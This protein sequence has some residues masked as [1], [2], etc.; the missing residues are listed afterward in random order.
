MHNC[1][2]LVTHLHLDGAVVGRLQAESGEVEHHFALEDGGS[3]ENFAVRQL[4]C[5]VENLE[6]Y[7]PGLMGLGKL[8]QF[9]VGQSE[10]LLGCH[11]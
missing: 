5:V 6:D 2:D 4:L 11:S 9:L 7:F 1:Q 3:L 10:N 8:N